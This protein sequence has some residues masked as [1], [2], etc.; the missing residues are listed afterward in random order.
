MVIAH[1][2]R[3]FAAS[4]S[5]ESVSRSNFQ[6]KNLLMQW[7]PWYTVT[8]LV[9]ALAALAWWQYREYHQELDQAR[10]TLH[11]QSHSVMNVLIG[12]FHSH[13]RRGR[14]FVEQV[15]GSLQGL[16]GAEDILAV[17]IASA[18]GQFIL[19]AGNTERLSSASPTVAGDFWDGDGFR[20]V[21]SF[22]LPSASSG[23]NGQF[24]GG[25][26]RG[27]GPP[28]VSFGPA[29]FESPFS[30]GG[31]FTATLV[32]DRSQVDI[33][34]RRA[35]WLRGSVVVAGGMLLLGVTLAWWLTIQ[36]ASRARLLEIETHH[37]R[38]L[39][40]A[41]AGLAH[42][43]RNPLGLIRGWAQ[44][45]AQSDSQSS[46][47]Q[48]QADAIVEECDRVTARINQFLAFARPAEPKLEPVCVRELI[49]EL[50]ILLEPDL[51]EKELALERK[52]IESSGPIRADREMLRQAL[53]NLVQNAIYAS[54]TQETV[55]ISMRSRHDRSCRIEVVNR[56]TA[57]PAAE[58]GSLFTPYF[59]T[60]QGGTGLGLAIVRHIAS[61][62]GWKAGYTPRL[63]GGSNFWL[64]GINV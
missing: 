21:E 17:G 48:Q 28:P 7:K 27:R 10:E 3:T 15:E 1:T 26:G 63:G 8:V 45:L 57:I 40:Q 61:M 64:D 44:R 53:F 49:D 52:S 51:S 36:A 32:L 22:E 50:A 13:R 24:R 58:V 35:A 39:S 47:Q 20:L 33:R 60:R 14:F 56:G 38:N 12:G 5:L 18:D 16:V 6:K 43:T 19:S 55:E 59:T 29:D 62:H 54:P 25:P 4:G 23:M 42:E 2:T 11:R 37:L 9:L 41:A 30:A 34:R 31:N 46:Q